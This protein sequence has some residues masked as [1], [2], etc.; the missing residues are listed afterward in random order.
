[1]LGGQSFP[2]LFKGHLKKSKAFRTKVLL[3]L[4][5]STGLWDT[6]NTSIYQPVD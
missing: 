4:T 3:T 5:E 6:V 2:V 1:M